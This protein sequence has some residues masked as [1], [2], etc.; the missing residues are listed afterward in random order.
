MS[1]NYSLV[2]TTYNEEGSILKFLRS[3]ATQTELPEEIVIVDGG[4][5]D[6]TVDEI[7]RFADR[8]NLPL[9][10]ISSPGSNIAEGRNEAI[11]EAGGNV[12]VV[13]DAGTELDKEWYEEM[14]KPFEKD[15]SVDVVAGYYLPKTTNLF[16]KM[17]ARFAYIPKSSIDS[18]DFLPSSRSIAFKKSAWKDVGGYPENLRMAEDTKFDIELRESG[19]EFVF[20]PSAIVYWNHNEQFLEFVLR[21]IRYSYW[22]GVAG[23]LQGRLPVFFRI[24]SSLILLAYSIMF[25]SA[26]PMIL[27]ILCVTIMAI[28]DQRILQK[29]DSEVKSGFMEELLLMAILRV[30]YEALTVGGYVVGVLH[31]SVLRKSKQ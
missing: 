2:C 12:I 21:T 14:I 15:G 16:Q 20:N 9:R 5:D 24:C 23:I 4:S 8:S 31:R 27:I 30:T 28:R 17:V 25:Q 26:I 19:K 7:E 29:L 1:N 11:K 6:N 10:L 22:D 13:T 18:D 3:I